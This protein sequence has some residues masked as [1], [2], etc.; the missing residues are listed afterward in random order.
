MREK[1]KVNLKTKTVEVMIE[2][3]LTRIKLNKYK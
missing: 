1:K 3:N 2:R